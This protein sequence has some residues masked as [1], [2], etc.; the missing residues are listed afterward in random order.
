MKE[1]SEFNSRS[2]RRREE[3]DQWSLSV[4]GYNSTVPTCCNCPITQGKTRLSL[5]IPRSFITP[6]AECNE[7]RG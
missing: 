7:S 4:D 6:D 3:Q 1:D 2:C 5:D